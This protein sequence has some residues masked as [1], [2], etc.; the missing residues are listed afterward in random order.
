MPDTKTSDETAAGALDGSELVRIVQGGNNRKT[1]TQDIADLAPAGGGGSGLFSAVLSAVPTSANTGLSTW[2]NQGSA[3]V[4]DGDTGIVVGAPSSGADAWALRE[5]AAPATPYTITALVSLT[6][7]NL[8]NA[9]SVGLGWD[10]G[11]KLHLI[12][13]QFQNA[14]PGLQMFVAKYTNVTTFSAA[15]Y[16][17]TGAPPNPMWLRIADDGTNVS[18]SWSAD[19]ANFIAAFSVAKASGFL[20][21]SGYSNVC[22]AVNPKN[23]DTNGG[24]LSWEEA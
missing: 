18:F 2:R 8:S 15:D 7:K 21:G 1:T 22:F 13:A 10:D 19:G 16:T 20:G 24:I 3:T 23:S 12:M 9:Q 5:K 17:S 4:A 11:T 14:F 6:S